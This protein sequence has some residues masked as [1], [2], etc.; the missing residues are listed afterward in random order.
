MNLVALLRTG[1]L[2]LQ[3]NVNLLAVYIQ[4][5]LIGVLDLKLNCLEFNL[6]ITSHRAGF[7]P[8]L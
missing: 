7:N 1:Y 6:K 3:K 2:N 5:E 8:A 4:L